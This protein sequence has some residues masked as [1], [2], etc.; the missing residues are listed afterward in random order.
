MRTEIGK[1]KGESAICF[2]RG[3]TKCKMAFFMRYLKKS[4]F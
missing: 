3:L 1:V 2:F 4:H